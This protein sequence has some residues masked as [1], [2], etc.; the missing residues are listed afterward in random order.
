MVKLDALED[1][2][3]ASSCESVTSSSTPVPLTS[4]CSSS[5]GQ[6]TNSDRP[7]AD[8]YIQDQQPFGSLKKSSKFMDLSY[9]PASKYKCFTTTTQH[10]DLV[11]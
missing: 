1:L 10:I 9:C 5:Q 8:Q 6:Y 7:E 4:S 11:S 2:T 3:A